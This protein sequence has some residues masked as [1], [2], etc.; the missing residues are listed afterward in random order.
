M[1]LKEKGQSRSGVRLRIW[2]WEHGDLVEEAHRKML[3]GTEIKAK[4]ERDSKVSESVSSDP[5]DP[6]ISFDLSF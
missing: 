4:K 3:E 2:V 1:G 5:E 6:V